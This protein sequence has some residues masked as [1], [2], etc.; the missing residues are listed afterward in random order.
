MANLAQQITAMQTGT[1]GVSATLI[2]LTPAEWNANHA[3]VSGPRQMLGS[4]RTAA[5]QALVDI[6]K[7]R[8]AL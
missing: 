6:G 4:T 2:P 7:V 8:A 1:T 5:L 3:I